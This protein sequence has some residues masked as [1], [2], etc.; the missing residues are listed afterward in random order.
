MD[1]KVAG[2]KAGITSTEEDMALGRAYANM[3][4]ANFSRDLLTHA[5]DLAVI[6]VAGSGWS[7]WGSPKR[8][9]ESLAGTPELD[10]LL[11]RIREPRTAAPVALAG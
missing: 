3:E 7:D 11:A 1:F 2:T 9:F 4:R 8:V 6:P 10:H 5:S